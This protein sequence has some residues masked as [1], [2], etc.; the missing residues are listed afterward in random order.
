MTTRFTL[1][2][3]VRS[4]MGELDL[5]WVQSCN[6]VATGQACVTTYHYGPLG[7]ARDV[8]PVLA[9]LCNKH[10]EHNHPHLWA[11]NFGEHMAIVHDDRDKG[12]RPR[13]VIED[14]G[15]DLA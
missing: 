9:W 15:E 2:L 14:D 13:P 3:C 7:D 4:S 1:Q 10:F 11:E 8:Q 5:C 6:Y 12:A